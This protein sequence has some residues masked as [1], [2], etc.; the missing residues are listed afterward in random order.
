MIKNDL[1]DIAKII[2]GKYGLSINEAK[3][4]T[5]TFMDLV[6]EGLQEDGLVKIKG[7]GTFKI[8]EVKDRESINVTT[9]E[10]FLI[11]GRNKVTFTPDSVMKEMVNKPFSQ[12]DTVVLN[13]G[14]DF[15]DLEQ[16]VGDSV[17]NEEVPEE[18]DMAVAEEDTPSDAIPTMFVPIQKE[19][20]PV[21]EQPLVAETE[22]TISGEEVSPE[23]ETAPAEETVPVEEVVPEEEIVPV[24]E[25]IAEE[26]LTEEEKISE[27]PVSD[28]LAEDI[29]SVVDSQEEIVSATEP[30]QG[31]EPIPELVTALEESIYEE[32][33]QE[34]TSPTETLSEEQ[35]SEELQTTD[36]HRLMDDNH[37][38]PNHNNKENRKMKHRHGRKRTVAWWIP[39]G[40]LLSLIVGI[41][42]GYHIGIRQIPAPPEIVGEEYAD[43]IHE[44]TVA[45]KAEVVKDDKEKATTV[46]EEKP[47]PVAEKKEAVAEPKEAAANPQ[48]V[49]QQPAKPATESVIKPTVSANDSQAL[50]NAK[51][52]VSKG[53]YNI[54]GTTETITVKPG[55]TMKKIS[56]FYLG[57]GMECYIQAYNNIDEVTEGMKLK[58]PQLKLKKK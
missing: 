11:P 52:M 43:Y 40:F 33:I 49:K 14:V 30:P 35:Y 32:P 37:Q 42:I 46:K 23:E 53:A 26:P 47:E 39:L 27:E 19:E 15:S 41:V 24:E 21:I 22:E 58:I 10:R 2:A 50:R 29:V 12:F 34:D 48:A 56:K 18:T 7:F 20:E 45:E 25:V 13:E 54:V 8:I 17:D 9:G 16:Q 51:Q 6:N 57:D 1:H 5:N 28:K 3:E 55:Q 4:F 31:E 44:S 38:T 36:V